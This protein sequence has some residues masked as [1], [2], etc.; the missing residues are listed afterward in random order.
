MKYL[1]ET[2][3]QHYKEGRLSQ[4]REVFIN[5]L[6][7]DRNNLVA[8]NYVGIIASQNGHS[9]TAL[10]YLESCE[11]QAP[12]DFLR[13]FHMAYCYRQLGNIQQSREC[14]GK[15]INSNS[16]FPPAHVLQGDICT[17]LGLIEPAIESYQRALALS[18]EL[19]AA[20][21]GL[22]FLQKDQLYQFS[23]SEINHVKHLCNSENLSDSHR[24]Q[25]NFA[26]FRILSSRGNRSEATPYLATANSL[27]K[28]SLKGHDFNAKEHGEQLNTT[29]AVFSNTLLKAFSAHGHFS[30]QPV[31]I[32]GMPRS[33]STL[34]EKIL[35]S[36]PQV[37]ANGE[38][39]HV[40]NI[41]RHHFKQATGQPYPQNIRSLPPELLKVAAEHYLRKSQSPD[42]NSKRLID[43]MPTNFEMLGIIQ[44]LFPNAYVI[45]TIRDP[46]DT[47][48]SCYQ[49]TLSA[50][51]TYSF[52]DLATKYQHYRDYMA[53]W[54]QQPGLRILDVHYEELVA[55]VETTTRRLVDYIELDWDDACLNYRQHESGTTSA[56]RLQ[57]RKPV[58]TS[59]IGAWKPYAE[60]L[61]PLYEKIK[62]YYQNQPL[63]D[64]MHST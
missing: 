63:S 60:H 42:G 34:V 3:I 17:D 6:K 56:S 53:H 10:N 40:K 7:Q 31:F 12:G 54:K 21:L 1:T 5:I 16:Q 36:H 33:G 59:S 25:A 4:A 47:L 46:M 29:K 28:A 14:I 15:S 45:H 48:W 30:K 13:L 62:R 8:R 22:S 26:M 37:H 51:Y 57:V 38:L 41:A 64:L 52:D 11:R 55:T 19:P 20:Y 39:L 50:K 18:P 24:S 61:A 44:L 49:Q 27:K 35:A 32:I 9:E 2:G 43:K 58:Y 23:D